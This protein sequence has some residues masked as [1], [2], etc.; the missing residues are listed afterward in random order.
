MMPLEHKS[1]IRGLLWVTGFLIVLHVL[2]I[3]VMSWSLQMER[4]FHV[5]LEANVPTWFSSFLWVIAALLSYQC[6]RL[7]LEAR[8][9]TSW[10]ILAGVFMFLSC[11]EVASFHEHFGA[12]AARSFLNE[13]TAEFLGWRAW[14]F[15]FMPLIIL[16]VVGLIVKLKPFLHGSR[17]AAK[18]LLLGVALFVT[19]SVLLEMVTS[20]LVLNRLW[21]WFWKLE[22]VLE[23]TLEMIGTITLIAGL[24]NHAE[25]LKNRSVESFRVLQGEIL[26]VVPS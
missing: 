14:P 1:L 12:I 9:Q 4:L 22:M 19:G 6:S 13:S 11:D 24:L 23:E 8:A 21:P 25:I 15:V 3:T 20:F 5:D 18:L 16:A 2:S 10:N 17:R 7:S 26:E